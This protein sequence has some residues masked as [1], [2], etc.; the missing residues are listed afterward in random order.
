MPG[1]DG[2]RQVSLGQSGAGRHWH[3]CLMA[4]GL[5][6]SMRSGDGGS[7]VRRAGGG[8]GEVYVIPQELVESESSTF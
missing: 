4:S 8:G 2:P 6:S 1:R 5:A 3:W 7:W